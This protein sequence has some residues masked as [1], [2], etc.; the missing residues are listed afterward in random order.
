MES[1]LMYSI[2]IYIATRDEYEMSK[3]VLAWLSG[4]GAEFLLQP[5]L[6]FPVHCIEQQFFLH[7]F[8]SV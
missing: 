6:F 4:F 3:F 2:N 7:H 1:L 8:H 5:L